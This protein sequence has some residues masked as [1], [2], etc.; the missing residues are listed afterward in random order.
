MMRKGPLNPLNPPMYN[1]F[2]HLNTLNGLLFTLE[3][4]LK[5]FDKL[6]RDFI[7]K[8]SIDIT[9]IFSG[10]S[11]VI[12]D[13]TGWTEEGFVKQYPS[14]K[15]ISKGE[16]Y[17]KLI[18]VLLARESAWTVSQAYEAYEKFLKDILATFLLENQYIAATKKVEK[19]ESNK[20]TH[21]LKKIPISFW[22]AY[23][24]Y[25]YKTNKDKLKFIRKICPE[26]SK[27]ETQ[28]NR[29][30][31]LTEWFD[32]V[33]ELRHSA[34]HS[35]FII[36]TDKMKNWSKGKREILKKYFS[37]NNTDQGY[38]LDITKDEATFCLELFSEYSFQIYKMMS[39]SRG[40]DWNILQ[41]GKK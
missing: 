24:D 19:F 28:N 35:Y 39:I 7:S 33:E 17:F 4:Q 30:I 34:T 21:N 29:E 10:N 36:K 11:L 3:N 2:Y 32:V 13:L 12:R 14:G 37:G 40:Y 9:R 18:M 27:S 8:S 20:K 5:G 15:F 25:H 23:L 26:I 1:L 38:K 22:R 16:E 41:K 31:N 6:Y